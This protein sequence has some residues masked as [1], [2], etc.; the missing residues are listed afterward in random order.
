MDLKGSK[1][2]KNLYRTFAGESRARTKYTFICRKG[3]K[4]RLSMGG[5]NI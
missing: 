5:R 4:R 2:E 1:T 3:K